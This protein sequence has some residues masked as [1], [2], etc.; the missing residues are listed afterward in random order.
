MNESVLSF[1]SR[2]FGG[3]EHSASH[4]AARA[5]P[6]FMK[7][8]LQ[9]A[10]D[11]TGTRVN[12]MLLDLWLRDIAGRTIG[13]HVLWRR[14]DNGRTLWRVERAESGIV[15]GSDCEGGAVHLPSGITPAALLP[16]PAQGATPCPDLSPAEMLAANLRKSLQRQ[17]ELLDL[18][19]NPEDTRLT[20]LISDVANQTLSAALRASEETLRAK[21]DGSRE[22]SPYLQSRVEEAERRVQELRPSTAGGSDA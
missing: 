12:P 6:T 10:A 17:A 7:V 1:W 4:V 20:R 18:P 2:E 14:G 5:S 19:L 11:P 3:G 8:L 16:A 9:V 13:E 22:I 15:E 21:R